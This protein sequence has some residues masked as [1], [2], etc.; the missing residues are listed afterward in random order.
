MCD[1]RCASL[2]LFLLS[3]ILCEA[4]TQERLTFCRV[5]A[6]CLV[7]LVDKPMEL[8]QIPNAEA[9]AQHHGRIGLVECR[10]AAGTSNPRK[11]NSRRA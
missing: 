5:I 10:I 7:E 11:A 6:V 3:T 9:R 8:L 4:Y 2:T 1:W